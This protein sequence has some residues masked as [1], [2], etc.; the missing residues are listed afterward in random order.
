MLFIFKSRL[1]SLES[2]ESFRSDGRLRSSD[3]WTPCTFYGCLTSDGRIA[4]CCLEFKVVESPSIR[5]I[6]V[7]TNNRDC[8]QLDNYAE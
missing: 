6:R 8:G 1:K 4:V 2:I 5:K 7:F 3:F